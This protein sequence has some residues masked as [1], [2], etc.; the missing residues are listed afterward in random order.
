MP[1]LMGLG[2]LIQSPSRDGGVNQ[3]HSYAFT[4]C[5]RL[6]YLDMHLALSAFLNGVF[7]LF[8]NRQSAQNKSEPRRSI[9]A[10]AKSACASISVV[11]VAVSPRLQ[12]NPVGDRLQFQTLF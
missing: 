5:I 3:S 12:L 4:V 7:V 8:R 11:R 6:G 10:L 9:S 1:A 2:G